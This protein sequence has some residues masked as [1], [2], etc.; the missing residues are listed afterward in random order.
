MKV[1]GVSL[2]K[3]FTSGGEVSLGVD[4][5]VDGEVFSAEAPVGESRGGGEA[6]TLSFEEAKAVWDKAKLRLEGERFGSIRE[7]DG[8]LI[9]LDGTPDKSKLGGN[10]ILGISIA[11]VRALAAKKRLPEWA[12]IREE[13]FPW[14]VIDKSPLILANFLEGGAHARN[15]LSFQEY[16]VI[17]E[18]EFGM[19][20]AITSLIAFYR[21][22]GE[23][24]EKKRGLKVLPL[25]DEGGYVLDFED[26][27]MPLAELGT[28]TF[29]LGVD[30]AANRF[31]KDGK[32]VFEGRNK[33][34]AEMVGIYA[35][36]FNKIDN[37]FYLEDPFA[38]VDADGFK[39]LRQKFPAKFVVGDDLT[40][41]NAARIEKYGSEETISAVIIKPNQAGTVTESCAAIHAARKYG[42]G[43]IV[44]HRGQE[45]GD[46]FIIHLAK[47]GGAEGV[48]IGAPARERILKYNEL[49][50]LY[51]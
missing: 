1:G 19:A 23:Q 49:L 35:E 24:L 25:G 41:T 14:G 2:R 48:K 42:L 37:F 34:S 39:N 36:Y 18:T 43:V 50:R 21:Q 28:A 10:V 29:R 26:N 17:A 31:Y 38:E 7:L 47:A 12:V 8:F 46:S 3:I 11:F 20:E 5:E 9:R 13:F 33:S 44:S 40:V 30:A 15:N 4:L 16:L 6:K 27:F 45:T 22:C 51:A 32:Y